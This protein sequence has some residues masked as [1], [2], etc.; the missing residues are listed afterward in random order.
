MSEVAS[1]RCP[2]LVLDW[3]A[4]Y[5]DGDLPGAVRGAIERHAAECGACRREIAS[6]EGDLGASAALAAPAP[7]RVFAR[8]MERIDQAP[9]ELAAPRAPG[10]RAWPRAA[11]AA[12]IAVVVLAGAAGLFASRLGWERS[13][14]PYEQATAAPLPATGPQLDVVFRAEAPLAE[15][16]AA[17]AELHANIV[18][19]PSAAGVFRVALPTDAETEAAATRLEGEGRGV[20]VYA[21]P[22]P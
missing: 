4:W 20:A 10:A 6:I 12:G 11:L 16:Q 1:L 3:I 19:G 7:E 15:I 14:P 8:V 22:A 13:N 17:L 18:A 2:Q 21:R 9:R 5:P